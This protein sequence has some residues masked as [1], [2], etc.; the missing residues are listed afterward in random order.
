MEGIYYEGRCRGDI[1]RRNRA[2]TCTKSGKNI[3]GKAG[4]SLVSVKWVQ[5]VF[6]E[7]ER[8]SAPSSLLMT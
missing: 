4:V 6:A 2:C 3:G 5:K 1:A 7:S 8:M